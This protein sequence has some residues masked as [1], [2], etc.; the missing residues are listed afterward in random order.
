MRS[1]GSQSIVARSIDVKFRRALCPSRS[2]ALCLSSLHRLYP[3]RPRLQRALTAVAM[4][5]VATLGIV[6]RR[7]LRTGSIMRCSTPLY[8]VPSTT[9][10]S[11]SV[12]NGLSCD[13]GICKHSDT[14]TCHGATTGTQRT[15]SS[16]KEKQRDANA[17]EPRS[18]L[19]KRVFS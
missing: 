6:T 11:Q 3:Y 15:A 9:P 17:R 8:R 10:V 7:T 1:N 5:V 13:V 12:R 16:A 4:L 18:A 14:L 2:V 19:I